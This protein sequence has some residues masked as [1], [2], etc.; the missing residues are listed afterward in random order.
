MRLTSLYR[1]PGSRSGNWLPARN[2]FLGELVERHDFNPVRER[3]AISPRI[4]DDAPLRFQI[5]AGVVKT[6]FDFGG[7]AALDLDG[8]PRTSGKCQHQI[9][10]STRPAAVELRLRAV[11]HP[12]VRGLDDQPLPNPHL[13]QD[14][15]T[16][17]PGFEAPEEYE[18]RRCRVHRH[19]VT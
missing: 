6:S 19:G 17:R 3:K 18:G 5:L 16:R 7:Q 9:N 8:P 14:A 1:P 15:L 13:R 12:G 2:Q 4:D 10:F 11:R